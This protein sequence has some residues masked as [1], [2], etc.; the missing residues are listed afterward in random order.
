MTTETTTDYWQARHAG[1]RAWAKGMYACMAAAELLI[2]HR[3]LLRHIDGAGLLDHQQRNEWRG[4]PY[5]TINWD[6]LG[7]LG[8]LSGGEHVS[9][10]FAWALIDGAEHPADLTDLAR[11]DPYN[12]LQVLSALA[13]AAGDER[14]A[15]DLRRLSEGES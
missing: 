6:R 1:L 10:S 15:A 14:L 13:L 2:G 12:R 5:T 11:L 8:F 7:E 3:T 9:L 4:G